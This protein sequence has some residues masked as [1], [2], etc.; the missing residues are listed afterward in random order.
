VLRIIEAGAVKEAIEM[1]NP[2]DPRILPEARNK[3]L[4]LKVRI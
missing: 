2:D 4:E 1:I 3:V